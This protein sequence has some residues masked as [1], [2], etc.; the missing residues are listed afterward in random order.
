MCLSTGSYYKL[1]IAQHQ[2]PTTVE[3]QRLGR[4]WMVVFRRP[5][6]MGYTEAPDWYSR[7]SACWNAEWMNIGGWTHQYYSDTLTETRWIHWVGE[8]HLQKEGRGKLFLVYFSTSVLTG[9]K[10]T[11]ICSEMCLA[12]TSSCKDANYTASPLWCQVGSQ[13]LSWVCFP[14]LI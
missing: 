10:G 8:F 12:L 9:G 6:A 4:A 7:Q 1:K 3:F 14:F 5:K 11:K 13:I 2:L